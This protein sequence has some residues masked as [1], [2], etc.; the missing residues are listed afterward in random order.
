MALCSH[1]YVYVRRFSIV[2]YFAYCS[3]LGM[4]SYDAATAFRKNIN[5]KMVYTWNRKL[6]VFETVPLSFIKELKTQGGVSINDVMFSCLGGAIRRYN[7]ANDC[8]VTKKKKNVLC[9]A[10]MPVA[11]PRPNEDKDDKTSVLKNKW[12]FLSSDFGV[13]KE[14]S[15]ERLQYVNGKVSSCRKALPRCTFCFTHIPL[16][17]PPSP[18]C[19]HRVCGR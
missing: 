2:Y 4:G 12:V 18:L 7:L 17:A 8:F 19:S 13:G 16:F 11:F 9:R 1:M 5:S 15:M 14:D 10:L 3:T 6:V